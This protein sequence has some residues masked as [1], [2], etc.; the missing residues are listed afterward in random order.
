MSGWMD[1]VGRRVRVGW[2]RR[3]D[4]AIGC[5][6]IMLDAIV[7]CYFID[8]KQNESL[9]TSPCLA[10]LIPR[11]IQISAFEDMWPVLPRLGSYPKAAT[12][13]EQNLENADF[14]NKL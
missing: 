7:Y 8:T 10:L 14:F 3:G 1:E 6:A 5:V 13:L 2:C 12:A 9:Y 11:T 4:V